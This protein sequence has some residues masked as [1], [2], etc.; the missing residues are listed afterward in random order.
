MGSALEVQKPK[1][2][3]GEALELVK[4]HVSTEYDAARKAHN[5]AFRDIEKEVG[6]QTERLD[7]AVID[8]GRAW[9]MRLAVIARRTSAG[10]RSNYSNGFQTS[11][12]GPTIEAAV[13]KIFSLIGEL[14][15]IVAVDMEVSLFEPV[16]K[17][18]YFGSDYGMDSIK[19]LK[20]TD[21]TEG[22]DDS[23]D[24]ESRAGIVVETIVEACGEKM[25]QSV[26]ELLEGYEIDVPAPEVP[27]EED[28]A[29][30]NGGRRR[31]K[32]A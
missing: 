19:K 8:Q 27:G 2:S 26:R 24:V 5:N 15:A 1:I 7:R 9:A 16:R 17:E 28:A 14:E 13:K 4:K 22:F 25:D 12:A 6:G 29:T 10:S 21:V 11:K 31:R 32:R 18:E 20:A 30:A 23:D 3:I